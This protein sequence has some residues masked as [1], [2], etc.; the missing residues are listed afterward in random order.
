MLTSRGQQGGS[1]LGKGSGMRIVSQLSYHSHTQGMQEERATLIFLG[2]MLC[3]SSTL[4][5][6]CHLRLPTNR[7]ISVSGALPHTEWL[8]DQTSRRKCRGNIVM[9][10]VNAER[11]LAHVSAVSDSTQKQPMHVVRYGKAQRTTGNKASLS[12]TSEHL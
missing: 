10:R 12:P 3:I 11:L 1:R 6:H 2:L 4:P 5:L 9:L 8:S 7:S